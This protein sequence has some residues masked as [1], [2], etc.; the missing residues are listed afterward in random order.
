MCDKV[1]VELHGVQQ[2]ELRL[3]ARLGRDEAVLL[4]GE[5][6]FVRVQVALRRVVLVAEAG[7]VI[8]GVVCGFLRLG[9]ARVH[10]DVELSL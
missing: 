7:L 4:S 5:L 8:V 2:L 10:A 6:F 3:D 1:R 9:G